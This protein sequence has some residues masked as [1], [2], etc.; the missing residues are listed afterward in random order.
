[1]NLLEKY[2]NRMAVAESVYKKS[3]N[4]PMDMNR[5][6]V[7]AKAL[8][9]TEKF[10]NEAFENST[11]T[12]RADMG[13]YK[14]FAL[15][16][17]NVA[18]PSLIAPELV[19]VHA[20]DSMSGYV[21]YLNYVAGS[22]KG[23]TAQGDVFNGVFGLGKVDPEYTSLRVTE[24]FVTGQTALAWTPILPD[25]F[26]DANGTALGDIKVIKASD[27][28]VLYGT[29]ASAEARQAGTLASMTFKDASGSS[30]SYTIV[31]NDKMAYAYNNVV[32][33]QNDLPILNAKLEAI[34]LV[35]HA[36]RIAIYYSQIAAFQAKQDY[37]FDLGDQLAEKAVGQ[38]R[39]EI[40]TEICDGLIAAAP[41]D[42][43]LQWSKVLPI[44]VSKAEHYEGF[45]EI[46]EMAKQV[47]YDRTKRFVPNYMLIASNILPILTFMK[48]FQ[49][50]PVSSINGPYLAGTLNGMKVFV[51]PNIAPG[52]FVVGVNGD[53]MMSSAAVYAVY[54]PIVPTQLLQYAD[55]GT[56]QGFST[57]YDFKILNA[58][59]L[60]AGQVTDVVSLANI[61]A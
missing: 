54:M 30:A 57:L 14:K 20:M 56:S 55:G 43:T 19:I 49:A 17:V 42:V 51:T 39:Y 11:G 4:G 38:L 24:T 46:I 31:A 61:G 25:M 26:K 32:I 36:R 9:N 59:L 3:N 47:V 60:V 1:M 6:L 53:D 22:N 18:L 10:L 23:Q 28:S 33:P 48:G 2:K 13:M 52:K 8:E 45:A 21:T 27:G 29:F 41:T 50:A 40:D 34:P 44:G 5:K 12:Q 37:G 35:A 7:I 16:L 15:N 58:N